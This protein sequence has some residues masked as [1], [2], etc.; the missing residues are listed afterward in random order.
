MSL[1]L[2]TQGHASP[3]LRANVL[4]RI[5]LAPTEHEARGE[6]VRLLHDGECDPDLKGYAGILTDGEEPDAA[7]T[8]PAISRARF[9]DHLS[10]GDIVA[11]QPT[12]SVRTLFRP[13][14]PHNSIFTTDRCNSYCVMCSQPPRKIDDRERIVEHLRLIELIARGAPS[15]IPRE[16]G[17]T[18]GE[19]T[20]LGDDLL[21]IVERCRDLL[22]ATALHILSNGRLFYYGSFARKL[23]EIEHPDLM[24]GVPLY[25]DLD[26]EHDRVVEAPGAFGQ[27]VIGLQNLGRF[28]V[29][30]EIRVVLHQMTVERLLPTAEFI[31]RNFPFAAHIALMGLEPIGLAVKNLDALWIDPRDYAE[32]L[33]AATLHLA[34]RGLHVSIYNH[35]LCAVPKSLWR[36]CRR[37]ISDW[38]NEYLAACTGC[39][40]RNQCGGFFASAVQR[41]ETLR[42]LATPIRP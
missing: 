28:G 23:G 13:G 9:L 36:F 31:Y 37:S 38:K 26:V 1:R 17:I 30:V 11:L 35:P 39:T 15:D 6:T 41:R 20:L 14:S 33:E 3:N 24:V 18:G 7:T 29:P 4:G 34:A 10:A 27:T 21:R 5:S 32:A 42:L 2:Q 8:V 40:V 25:S 12:G 22:P 19:P 16:L